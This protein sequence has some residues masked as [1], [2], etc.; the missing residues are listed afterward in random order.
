MACAGRG[1]CARGVP[2][3]VLQS[4]LASSFDELSASAALR[5]GLIW[6][7]GRFRNGSWPH[8]ARSSPPTPTS[9]FNSGACARRGAARRGAR[10][11]ARCGLC[12]RPPRARALKRRVFR[13][14]ARRNGH[15]ARQ[16]RHA[17][18]GVRRLVLRARRPGHPAGECAA[19]PSSLGSCSGAAA[20]ARAPRS[21]AIAAA[22][23]G[24]RP[25][26]ARP[27]Q[28]TGA[29][30]TVAR[31][32]QRLLLE[33][34]RLTSTSSSDAAAR[35]PQAAL[36]GQNV[37]SFKNFPVQGLGDADALTLKVRARR[38]LRCASLAALLSA[39]RC[40][41]ASR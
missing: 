7:S 36:A 40:F 14:S 12:T 23:A 22:A 10:P 28:P 33:D 19:K 29:S 38:P 24:A 6:P 4:P 2:E 5:E 31:A 8:H 27:L 17:R 26:H 20:R 35:A 21:A 15:Q 34:L 3:I 32:W 37:N 41:S 16:A 1:R 13:F 30:G 25:L 18:P 39:S 11:C 9:A